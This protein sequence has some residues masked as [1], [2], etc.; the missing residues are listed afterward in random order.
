MGKQNTALQVAGSHSL[1]SDENAAGDVGQEP[2]SSTRDGILL[3]WKAD[4][5]PSHLLLS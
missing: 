2:L 5:P 1:C 4:T 3:A